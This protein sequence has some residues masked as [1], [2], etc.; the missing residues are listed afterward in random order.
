[1]SGVTA[2]SWDRRDYLWVAEN[3]TTSVIMPTSNSSTHAQIGNNFDGKIIGLG[4]APDGVRV[5][6]IVQ[7]ASGSRGPARGHRQRRAVLRPG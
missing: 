5:A 6:A 1:M 7:T 2:I 3:N 4:I